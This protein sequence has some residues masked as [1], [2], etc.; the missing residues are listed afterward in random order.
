MEKRLA[1]HPESE[2]Q[3]FQQ[4]KMAELGELV[5]G[6]LHEIN[7][8]LSFIYANLGN[9]LKFCTRLLDLIDGLDQVA[10]SDEARQELAARKEAIKYYYLRN[11]ITEMIASS[12]VG[13]ERMRETIQAYKSFSRM[14]DIVFAE[15]DI[16]TAIDSILALLHH[17]YKDRIAIKKHY[18]PI[19]SLCCSIAK[20]SQVFMN[21]LVNAIQAIEGPGEIEIT[22]GMEAGTV[23][24]SIRDTGCGMP[25]SVIMKIFDPFFTTKPDGV[26]TGLGLSIINGIMKQ[27]HGQISVE[28]A[29]GTGTTFILKLPVDLKAEDMEQQQ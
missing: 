12:L 23:V 29:P 8:P 25:E 7:N 1:S 24:I 6:I 20:L 16:H 13:A 14:S 18:G 21:L 28:S 19:P 5:T 10:L 9:L 2:K 11:R 27:H 3:L 17:Q 4:A 22:T 26:G 15:A